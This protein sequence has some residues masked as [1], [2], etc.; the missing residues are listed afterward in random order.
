MD[1]ACY[2]DEIMLALGCDAVNRDD[3]RKT[4][5]SYRNAIVGFLRWYG[6]RPLSQVNREHVRCY[7]ELLVD[8]GQ[9]ASWVSV[10]TQKSRR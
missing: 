5:K 9:G 2:G 6:E 1:Q 8:S 3:L 10:F 7:L 4:I